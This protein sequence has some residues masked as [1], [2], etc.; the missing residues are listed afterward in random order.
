MWGGQNTRKADKV[1]TNGER[2]YWGD[3]RSRLSPRWRARCRVPESC[4]PWAAAA[5]R[6]EQGCLW[7]FQILCECSRGAVFSGWWQPLTVPGPAPG[8]G[9]RPRRLMTLRLGP[10]CVPGTWGPTPFVGPSRETESRLGGQGAGGGGR[11]V[12]AE[13]TR[14]PLWGMKC[15]GT[16]E[17]ALAPVNLLDATAL[18]TESGSLYVPRVSPP[19]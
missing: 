19:L 16:G 4:A 17:A 5:R 11:G 3:G 1:C 15:F 14:A 9:L 6:W 2:S 12:T 13:W 18:G 7:W 8:A 10:P